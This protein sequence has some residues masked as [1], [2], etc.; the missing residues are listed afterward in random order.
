MW[1]YANPNPCRTEEPDCVV[2]AIALATGQTWDEVHTGLCLLSGE[3][4]TMPSVNWLWGLYLKRIGF[5]RFTMPDSCPECVTVEEFARRFP[6][7]TYVIGTGSHAV[8]VTD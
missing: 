4:C 5:E 7:G 1:R 3:K 6:E 2:R 8:C